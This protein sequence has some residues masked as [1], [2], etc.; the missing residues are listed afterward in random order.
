MIEHEEIAGVLVELGNHALPAVKI[1]PHKVKPAALWSSKFGGQPY[2][3]R[4][5][6]YPHSQSGAPLY[7]LAQLNFAELPAL[8]GYPTKGLLQF[9]IAN[10]PSYGLEFDQPLDRQLAAPDGYR[11]IY[12]ADVNA[13]VA[14]L[15]TDLPAAAAESLLPLT[16]EY[17][18]SFTLVQDLPAPSDYRFE[19]IA[20]NI[21]AIDESMV[22]ALY[23]RELGTGS[24]LGGYAYFTQEDPRP[25]EKSGEEWL[26]LF[27]MDTADDDDG[28]AI[29]WGDCGV[30][31]F[32]IQPDALAKLDFSRV[33]YSWDCC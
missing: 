5:M 2:W 17:A 28:V 14:G 25:Y 13:D 10:D 1:T 6:T 22:D 26:L 21:A 11:I 15:V 4:G 20:R 16:E 32:F 3:P 12:H 29:M 7:L 18:L 9:F 19:A 33:W 31:N 24:K 27:Q 23:D 30:G 8:S